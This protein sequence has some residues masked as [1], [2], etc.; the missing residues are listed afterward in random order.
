MI[1]NYK[2]INLMIIAPTFLKKNT[3]ATQRMDSL[4]NYMIQQGHHISLICD[5]IKE[6]RDTRLLDKLSIYLVDNKDYYNSISKLLSISEFNII[7]F[8]LGPYFVLP[9]VHKIKNNFNIKI[10]LDYRDLWTFDI[11]GFYDYFNPKK[12]IKRMYSYFIELKAMNYADLIVTVTDQW[13]KKIVQYFHQ[14]Q[15]KVFVIEN[16][17]DENINFNAENNNSNCDK[18]MKICVFGKLSYY[19]KK[20]TRVAFKGINNYNKMYKNVNLK[21]YHI[22]QKEEYVNKLIKEYK[23]EDLYIHIGYVNYIEGITFLK[24]NADAFL[25]IDNRMG[26]L[27]TKYY[28][29]IALNKPI[30]FIGPKKAILSKMIKKFSNG[31]SCQKKDE[32]INS[33]YQSVLKSNLDD[34]L[35]IN[36]YSRITQNKRY[37]ELMYKILD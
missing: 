30:I 12:N 22:G 3:V 6:K 25:I 9:I 20:Y 7:L 10:I 21:I 32:V 27:G 8:T 29:Y 1:N 37:C 16:G 24:Q 14:S 28:D 2:K 19:S 5:N 18:E 13:K 35:S 34:D 36:D 26:A 31:Y 11:R 17:F 4:I 15:K 33:L 23:M